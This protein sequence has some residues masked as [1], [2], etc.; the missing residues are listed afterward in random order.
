MAKAGETGKEVGRPKLSGEFKQALQTHSMEALKV[1]RNIMNS[2][3]S[4]DCDRLT[5]AKYILDKALGNNFQLYDVEGSLVDNEI[6]VRIV[7]AKERV[8]EPEA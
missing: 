8:E 1:I 2:E 6:K 7:R 5:A 4:K 3:Y